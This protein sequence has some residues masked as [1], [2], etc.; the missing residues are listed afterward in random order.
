[1]MMAAFIHE[2]GTRGVRLLP[3]LVIDAPKGALR[4]DEVERIRRQKPKIMAL[5]ARPQSQPTIFDLC[6]PEEQEAKIERL[7]RGDGWKPLP[8]AAAPAYSIVDRC[9]EHGVALHID[10]DGDL[11]IGKAGAKADEPTQPWPALLAEIEANLEPVARLVE[12]GWH[13]RTNFPKLSAV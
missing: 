6:A 5:L 8:P 9:R 2:L 1:M 13:L 10:E 12:A 7:T 11:V 4:P 3:K